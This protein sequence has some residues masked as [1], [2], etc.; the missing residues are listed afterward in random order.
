MDIMITRKMKIKRYELTNAADG[1]TCH[2][3]R[4]DREQDETWVRTWST[5]GRELQPT[6]EG[7]LISP[8]TSIL[9]VM[10]TDE[11]D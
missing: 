6:P 3:L 9:F 10:P 5:D 2:V 1:W 4:L 11:E 8:G 7:H